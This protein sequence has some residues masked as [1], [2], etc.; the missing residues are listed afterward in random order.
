MSI[1]RTP[2]TI[3]TLAGLLS[4]LT[5]VALAQEGTP[6]DT[7]AVPNSSTVIKCD[8]SGTGTVTNG[9]NA[10]TSTANNVAGTPVTQVSPFGQGT[11]TT[12]TPALAKPVPATVHC[13]PAQIRQNNAAAPAIHVMAKNPNGAHWLDKYN[14]SFMAVKPSAHRAKHTNGSAVY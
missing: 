8:A 2:M 4:G 6:P 12:E 3:L 10:D 13:R 1:P 7:M 14:R 9:A 5:T 11:A